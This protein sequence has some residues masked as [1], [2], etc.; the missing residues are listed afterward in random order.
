MAL[1]QNSIWEQR[2]GSTWTAMSA[3]FVDLLSSEQKNPAQR[4]LCI[5]ASRP[6]YRAGLALT[7][8]L[9]VVTVTALAR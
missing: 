8:P 1:Q 7:S 6:Q 5:A 2:S 3:A 4:K 9:L